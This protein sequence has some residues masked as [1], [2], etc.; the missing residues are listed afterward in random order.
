M[1]YELAQS[2][3]FKK[4]FKKILRSGRFDVEKYNKIISSLVKGVALSSQY[5][6]HSLQG[7][8]LTYRE[9]HIESDILLIYRTNKQINS[10]TLVDI[11]SHSYLFGR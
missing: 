9:C 8:F 2:H 4:S 3:R 10:L 1:I 11:G 5:N 7:E 6:D